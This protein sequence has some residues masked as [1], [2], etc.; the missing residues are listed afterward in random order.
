MWAI[1]LDVAVPYTRLL[2]WLIWVM[3]A[4]VFNIKLIPFRVFFAS[5]K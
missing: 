4:V 3:I 1:L 5:Y 2:D